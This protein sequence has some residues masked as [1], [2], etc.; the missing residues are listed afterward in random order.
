[1]QY[2]DAMTLQYKGQLPILTNADC[3]TRIFV[4]CLVILSLKYDAGIRNATEEHNT[5]VCATALLP[6]RL[7]IQHKRH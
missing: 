4:W 6:D 7:E 3:P 2:R 5:H 1:M